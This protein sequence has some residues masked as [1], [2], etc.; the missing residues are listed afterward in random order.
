MGMITDVETY[1]TDGCG[2]CDH[3]ETP[4][5]KARIW[6]GPLSVLRE[7]LLSSRLQ[8]EVKWGQP[9]YTLGGKNVAML[10]S[11][12]DCCGISFFKGVLIQDDH[13]L[14]VPAG[15]NSHVA[16]LLKI[17]SEMDAR[18]LEPLIHEYLNAAVEIEK[19][20][21]EVPKPVRDDTIPSI[22]QERI[23]ADE[24]FRKAWDVL[25]PG[26]Q[27]SYIIHIGSA[28]QEKTQYNRLEKALPKIL[29]GKGNN[30]Y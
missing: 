10:F 9:T 1:F 28:K 25:T 27:R 17:T 15:P 7:V 6:S 21:K 3:F 12:K 30:E 19:S 29:A 14:L 5:C 24:I 16:R 11:F 18:E 8:E 13:K 23:E 26:R 22:I 2:R 4:S 20:G